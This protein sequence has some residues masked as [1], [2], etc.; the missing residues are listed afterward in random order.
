MKPEAQQIYDT[1]IP[2]LKWTTGRIETPAKCPLHDDQRASLTINID[3]SKWF[4]HACNK[5]GA[6]INLYMEVKGVDFKTA[7]SELGMNTRSDEKKIAATYDY[8]NEAGHLLYQ[9][10]RYIPKTFKQ[11]RPNGKGGWTWSILGIQHVPYNLI[12]VL[13]A[14]MVCIVEGEKDVETLRQMGVV[15]TT[16][17]GGAGKW[18]PELSFYFKGKDIVIIPDN[19]EPGKK[20]AENVASQLCKTTKSIKVVEL[21]GLSEKGDVSDWITVKG[22]D[23]IK[24]KHIVSNTPVWTP[25]SQIESKIYQ[26]RAIEISEFLSLEFPPREN[27]LNPWLPTQG[28]TMIFGPRGIGKTYVTLYIAVTV[29]AGTT[30]WGR[31]DAPKARGVLYLDGEMPA[32]V[33]QERLGYIITSLDKEPTASLRIITPDLQEAGMP[34]LATQQGQD[35]IEPYLEGIGLVVVDNISTL[36]RVGRENEADSWEPVQGWALKLRSRGVSVLFVHHAGKG[37][38]QRGTSRREDILDTIINL[39]HPGDYCPEQGACF[40][41]HFEKARG[42]YGDAVKPFEAKLVARSGKQEW[43]V[44]DLEE[45]LTEKIADL[46]QDGI[47]QNEIA[48]LLGISK[49]AVSKHKKKANELRLL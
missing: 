28:L 44:K 11:R 17:S 18:R 27:V 20:H 2:G 16:N 23:K 7:M 21:P 5:G 10:V 9:V 40:H 47:A 12:E 38:M 46:L 32:V 8:T 39:K 30:L 29:S 41:V 19:D 37:G 34:N 6:P 13:K 22:N 49:G 42:V 26:V 45:S 3:S 24:L 36:C 1:L 15:G 25:P 35:A 33:M 4:C 14:E 48:E 43:Q 31:W